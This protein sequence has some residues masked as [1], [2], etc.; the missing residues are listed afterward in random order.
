MPTN[1]RTAT[2]ARV[3]AVGRVICDFALIAA[4]FLDGDEIFTLVSR[5]VEEISILVKDLNILDRIAFATDTLEGDGVER[6]SSSRSIARNRDGLIADN[7]RGG[8]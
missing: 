4:D 1:L 7:R 8:L 6:V 2:D 3:E 5:A